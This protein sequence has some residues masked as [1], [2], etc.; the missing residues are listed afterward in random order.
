[1]KLKKW[2][3]GGGGLYDDVYVD[4][5]FVETFERYG[6]DAPA[7][8]FATAFLAKEYPCVMPIRWPVTIFF[9][10]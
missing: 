9:M 6:L 7:D 8:S 5:T 3:D 10:A 2:Y 4:L 1:M